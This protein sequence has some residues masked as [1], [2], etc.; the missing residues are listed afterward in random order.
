M[1]NDKATPQFTTAAQAA[2]LRFLTWCES[3]DADSVDADNLNDCD[4]YDLSLGFFIA[5]GIT[6]IATARDLA[7]YARYMCQYSLPKTPWPPADDAQA[8]YDLTPE[9]R[10]AIEAQ[11]TASAQWVLPPLYSTPGEPNPLWAMW[12]TSAAVEEA[13]CPVS[14]ID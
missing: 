5:N 4:W 7:E 11:F 3:I 9:Q 6:D 14:S 12:Q 10:Q 1:S 2:L 13:A 8:Y